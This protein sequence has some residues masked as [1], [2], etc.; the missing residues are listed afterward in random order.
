M[1][2][3]SRHCRTP[4]ILQESATRAASPGLISTLGSWLNPGTEDEGRSSMSHFHL[5]RPP[6]RV[7]WWQKQWDS[8]KR[9]FPDRSGEQARS[10]ILTIII[11]AVFIFLTRLYFSAHGIPI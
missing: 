8:F 2:G 6:R 3:P 9:N 1:A 11:F 7:P 10:F 5:H 4:E